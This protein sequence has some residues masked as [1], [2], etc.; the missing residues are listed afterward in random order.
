MQPCFHRRYWPV[1]LMLAVGALATVWLASGL[2][3]QAMF[4]D[5][6]RFKLEAASLAAL[7]ESNMERYEERLARLADHCAQFQELPPRVWSFRADG[8]VDLNGNLPAVA[9]AAYCP[10]VLAADFV[11]HAAHGREVFGDR[12][13]FDPAPRPGRDL[14]LPIWQA[15]SRPGFQPLTRGTDLA[16]AGPHH[17]ALARGLVH[18]RGGVTGAPARV[19]CQD[20]GMEN[21]FWFT[22]A[23]FKPDQTPL[24]GGPKATESVEQHRRRQHEFSRKTAIGILAAF[25]STDRLLDGGFNHPTNLA[26]LHVQLFTS[27]N[28]KPQSLLNPNSAPSPN[29]RHREII[30]QAWYAQRWSLAVT[31]TPKFEA[32]SKRYRAWL[33][34]AA[35]GGL[36][37]LASALLGVALRARHRQEQLTDQIREAR[38][39]LAAAQAQRQKLSH[40]LHDNAVQSLYAIQ[41]GLGDSLHRIEAAPARAR[42]QL[43]AARTALDEV[44]AE[45]RRFITAEEQTES[46]ADLLVV[47]RSLVQRAAA[48]ATARIELHCDP[49][50]A[51]RLAGEHAVQLANI[52]REALSNSLRHAKAHMIQ[53]HLR[54]EATAVVLEVTDDGEGFDSS[55]PDRHGVGLASLANRAEQIGGDLKI[56]STSGAGTRVT[57]RVPASPVAPDPP[58]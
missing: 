34:L 13:Q 47:L 27:P 55:L 43:V 14:A 33:M 38:D 39:A 9:H 29:P 5:Q 51:S 4:L 36:T 54:S 37:L 49:D 40:D 58:Q 18:R 30:T 19:P 20:G 3:E 42:D 25:I 35:G 11:A 53:L 56:H 8:I 1:W 45:I 12:H 46:P 16:E 41:L 22:L 24:T 23:L 32:D 7:V 15:W 21:G 26:R 31:S 44:I 50:A 57:V 28:P 52:A 48:G 6:Q 17:P 2:H 10:K